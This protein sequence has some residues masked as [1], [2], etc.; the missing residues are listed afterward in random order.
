MTTKARS[1]TS[2]PPRGLNIRQASAYWG[3]SPGTFKK[4]VRLGLV[5]PP[6]NLPGLD[7]NIWDRQVLDCAM[8]AVSP[9]AFHRTVDNQE[10]ALATSW[11][12][13]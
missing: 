2:I 3:V 10:T 7:R 4:M 12:D 11:D 9:G 6:L 1:Q 5:P 8:D 13:V